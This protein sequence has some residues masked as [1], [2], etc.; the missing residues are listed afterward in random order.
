MIFHLG[1]DLPQKTEPLL[2]ETLAVLTDHETDII[3]NQIRQN[4]RLIDDYLKRLD[5]FVN[6]ERYPAKAA[7][8]AKMRRKLDLLMEEND[9]F[10]QVLWT[11]FQ[12]S[13]TRPKPSR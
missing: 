8:L 13:E 11:H 4:S 6:K 2:D 5:L 3:K 12:R 1:T 7:F 9:T 10:R